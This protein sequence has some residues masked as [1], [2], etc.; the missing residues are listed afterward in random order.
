MIEANEAEINL[1]L[2]GEDITRFKD[3]IRDAEVDRLDYRD[4]EFAEELREAL[5]IS[6]H[7]SREYG[8]W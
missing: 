7:Y 3:L 8:D 5:G 6:P 4:K 1:R 2:T